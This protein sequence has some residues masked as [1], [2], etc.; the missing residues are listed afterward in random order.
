MSAAAEVETIAMEKLDAEDR[1]DA[2]RRVNIRPRD[3]GFLRSGHGKLLDIG[4]EPAIDSRGVAPMRGR[5]P[6]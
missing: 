5:H 6:A 1:A 2:L 3:D 4:I